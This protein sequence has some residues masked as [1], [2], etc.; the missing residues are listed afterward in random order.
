MSQLKGGI[1]TEDPRLDRV[2][3]YDSRSR[4]YQVRTLLAGTR[5]KRTAHFPAHPTLNQ[6]P[7]GMCVSFSLATAMNA[8]PR[9]MKPEL[10][11]ADAKAAYRDAQRIDEWPGEEPA[12]SGTSVLAGLKVAQARGWIGS[13]WWCGA[14]SGSAIDD[15]VDSLQTIGSVIFGV[16][17][18]RSMHATKPGGFLEVDPRSGLSGYHAI[19]GIAFRYAAIPGLGKTKREHVVLQNTWGESWGGKWYGIGGHC[20]VP[21]EAIEQHL[22]P[23]SVYGECAVPVE[24]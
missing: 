14:G 12:Y 19:A 21:V 11:Y 1:T 17:W 15:V 24:D 3:S 13:Y 20:F 22:L 5:R 18:Y 16:P 9:R 7:D 23:R 2:P 6:G 4:N 8:S 10:G